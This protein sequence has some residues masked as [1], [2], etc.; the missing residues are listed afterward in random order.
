MRVNLLPLVMLAACAKAG[1]VPPRPAPARAP[2]TVAANFD[3]TWEAVI[4]IFAKQTIPIATIEKASGIV[5]ATSNLRGVGDYANCGAIQNLW[6]DRS[7]VY[8]T[9]GEF[10]VIVRTVGTGSTV[11]VTARFTHIPADP[12]GITAD[13]VSRGTF[14]KYFE[15]SVKAAA[16]GKRP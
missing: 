15:D 3:R 11:L 6:G 5:A 13:C 7:T 4:D 1:Y 2:T 16:E 10:N 12:R 8:A 9:R 14:E